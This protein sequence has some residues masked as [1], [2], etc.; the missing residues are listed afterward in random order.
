M[1]EPRALILHHH[2]RF[3]LGVGERELVGAGLRPVVVDGPEGE[4]PPRDTTGLA[5]IVS[6][7]GPMSAM[8]DDE[9]PWM[10]RELALLED[11][12]RERVPVL[13]LGLGARLL[14]RAAGWG[15]GP[16]VFNGR[17]WLEAGWAPVRR[18]SGAFADSKELG[19][20]DCLRALP[21]MHDAFHFHHESV[22]PPMGAVVVAAS[23]VDGAQAFV[24]DGMH[25]GV[26][27]ML[28]ANEHGV[29]GVIEEFGEFLESCGVPPSR[30]SMDTI[31]RSH[32]SELVASQVFARFF[33]AAVAL[34]E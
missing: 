30:A 26:Q 5:C 2:P 6:L 7:G 21:T 28:D 25:V 23:D 4:M 10:R 1:P 9:H 32:E 14:A 33:G 15:V 16:L 12:I 19:L 22:T 3:G 17:H 27:F 20:G 8:A 31:R 34:R 29:F 24:V 13:G 11:A 18:V